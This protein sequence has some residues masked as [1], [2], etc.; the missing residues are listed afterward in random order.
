MRNILLIILIMSTVVLH[1]CK[2]QYYV[3]IKNSI[4]RIGRRNDERLREKLL[5]VFD[6]KEKFIGSLDRLN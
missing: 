5:N 6:A 3:T 1:V 4:P 2:S